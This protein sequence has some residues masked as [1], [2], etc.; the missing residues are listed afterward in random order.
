M[1]PP[2]GLVWRGLLVVCFS[3]MLHWIVI[4]YQKVL[5]NWYELIIKSWLRIYYYVDDH[6]PCF[7]WLH[8]LFLKPMSEIHLLFYQSVLQ[9][10]IHFN[11]F[12]QRFLDPNFVWSDG[13]LSH[14]VS[15]KIF[16]SGYHQS[17]WRWFLHSQI[18][19][20][21]SAWRYDVQYLVYLLYVALI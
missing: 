14:K 17:S 21:R 20:W 10:F 7:Q 4:L 2:D 13:I 5:S 19:L 16:T 12:L 6:A 11:M 1:L 9:I 18:Q 8:A 15:W 3:S